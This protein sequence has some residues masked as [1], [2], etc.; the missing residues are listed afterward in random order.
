MRAPVLSARPSPRRTAARAC[1]LALA[2]VALSAS[3]C[4]FA[5]QPQVQVS[6][7]ASTLPG[8]HYAWVAMPSQLPAESDQRVQD[9]Q[10]RQRLQTA[11]DKALQG[12]GYQPA[13]GPSKADFFVAYRVGVQDVEQVEVKEIPGHSGAPTPQA[14][15]ECRAGGCSQLVTPGSTG[16]PM[17]KTTVRQQVE[18]ALMIEIL[19][20]DT[21]RVLWRSLDRGTVKRGDGSQARLDAVARDALA[22]LPKARAKP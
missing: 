1:L 3:P 7:P 19:E 21:V 6:K 15:I 17:L 5:Q 13:S 12:K 2:W 9:P 16:V 10:F 22:D 14:A 20:P 11:L 8:T 18:G 4:L